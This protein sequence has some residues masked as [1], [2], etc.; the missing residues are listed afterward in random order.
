MEEVDVLVVGGGFSGLA[1][2][3]RMQGQDVT[4]RVLEAR[5]RVG[6]RVFSDR[7]PDGQL[8][9]LGGQWVGPTHTELRALADEY[10]QPL[11]ATMD[12]GK[13]LLSVAGRRG[14]FR[15][16]SVFLPG[17]PL[18][19]LDFSQALLRLEALARRVPA[20][21]T[22][23]AKDALRSDAMS[24]QD[25]LD[26]HVRTRWAREVLG[27]ALLTVLAVP[28]SEIS[29]LHALFYFSSSGSIRYLIENR[30][31]AQQDIFVHGAQALA[32]AM[33]S[34]LVDTISYADP[35]ISVEQ[36]AHFVQ[37]RTVR[38]RYRAARVILAVPPP[39]LRHIAFDPWLPEPMQ[40]QLNNYTS[41]TVVKAVASYASPFWRERGWSG[42]SLQSSGVF[43]AT[44]DASK[45]ASAPPALL[46]F[47]FGKQA[48]ALL[49]GDEATRLATLGEGFVE[50]FGEDARAHTS[51]NFHSW[52][53]DEWT[54]GGYASM[55]KPMG[56]TRSR[57]TQTERWG[58]IHWAA[59][60]YSSAFNGYIEGAIRSG[61]AAAEEVLAL[62]GL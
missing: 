9:E 36:S 59:S 6:G 37:V 8:V 7:T 32:D 25:W 14:T 62:K 3:K 21:R 24:L 39:V 28:L 48:E 10:K 47:A 1:A 2:A 61:Y 5:A 43:T 46:G 20:N 57:P 60:E 27:A 4:F 54:H 31:G 49:E 55:L 23:L 53:E 50:V 44:F 15:A 33:A 22:W 40:V 13:S 26:R 56:W 52:A 12:Q 41:G 30:G 19:F 35:V 42:M 34:T 58:R 51:L 17:R 18:E 29:L 16:G 38:A 45:G 11:V